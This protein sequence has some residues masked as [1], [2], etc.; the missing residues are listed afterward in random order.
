MF[1]KKNEK[2]DYKNLNDVIILSKR[3]LKILFAILILGVVL[4]G[5]SVAKE[6]HVLNIIGSIL[7]SITPL[8]IGVIVAWL[9]NP[10]VNFLT[11]KKVNRLLAC[12]FVFFG[13][14]LFIFLLFRLIIPQLVE[15]INDFIQLLPSLFTTVS[16]FISGIFDK[17]SNSN[18]DLSTI[19]NNIYG[20]IE[21]FSVNLTSGLPEALINTISGVV[22]SVGTFLIGL[23]IGF[24][25]L[26]D[27]NRVKHIL[28]FFPKNS[29]ATIKYIYGKINTSFRD[30]L[31]GTLLIS[32]I[33]TVISFIGYSI[34]GLPSPLL[35]A[36][37]C[38]ITNVIPYIGPWIGG[39]ICAIVGFTIN[40][41]VGI[42]AAVI[43]F[44]IQQIDS[45]VLQPLIM[46]K[47]MKL[48]PVVIMVGLLIFGHFF[49]IIGMII[50]TPVIA[51]FK[52]LLEFFDEKYELINRLK[53]KASNNELEGE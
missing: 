46:G 47:T 14:I 21:T 29:H 10:L 12:I 9:F 4:I 22:S 11:S 17:F 26:L 31:S 53:Q 49:G 37:I 33:V 25:L 18:I 38:G 16:N 52:I 48:H 45:I 43:A 19:E 51:V 30:F 42:L 39:G 3:I 20:A 41:V 5:I 24:Y 1:G 23:V 28:D 36:L 6:L 13:I 40:P 34:I 7:V 35:F 44:V 32:L 2:L 27:F 8:F 15:Q 50:A